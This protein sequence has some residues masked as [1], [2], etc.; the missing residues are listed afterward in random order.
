MITFY[1]LQTRILQESY[2]IFALVYQI[3]MRRKLYQN[4]I[5]L[6]NQL[7]FSRNKK[8]KNYLFCGICNPLNIL[9]LYIIIRSLQFIIIIIIIIITSK[10]HQLRQSTW[11][12][13]E[14]KRIKIT[15]FMGSATHSTSFICTSLLEV[16]NSAT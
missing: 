9:Y 15:C 1:F 12:S 5:N 11:C 14:T 2:L 7:D 6:G 3:L 16:Y 13:L 8:N 4:G 10:W